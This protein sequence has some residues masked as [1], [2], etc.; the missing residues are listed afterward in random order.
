MKSL[1]RFFDIVHVKADVELAE[2]HADHIETILV[3]LGVPAFHHAKVANAIDAGV[4]PEIDKDNFAP[5]IGDVVRNGRAL[6]Q[7]YAI[8]TEIRSGPNLGI[9]LG[10][11]CNGGHQ[12]EQYSQTS[13]R[14]FPG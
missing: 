4:L 2:M 5:I 9:D 13:T 12:E 10:E 7:P 6:I 1:R 3:I 8:A 14:S 11:R